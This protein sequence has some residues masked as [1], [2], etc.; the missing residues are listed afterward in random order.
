M[1]VGNRC[2]AVG[3]RS[4]PKDGLRLI[5]AI[6]CAMFV[7]LRR[8]I[9]AVERFRWW[10]T[11]S[12]LEVANL[13]NVFGRKSQGVSTSSYYGEARNLRVAVSMKF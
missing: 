9:L 4:L 8:L 13:Y 3:R 10:T 2:G 11:A 5:C 6:R 7:R 12:L 1:T